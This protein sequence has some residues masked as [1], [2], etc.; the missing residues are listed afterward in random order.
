MTVL[1][2]KYGGLSAAAKECGVSRQALKTIKKLSSTKGGE[3]ARKA[4]GADAEFTSEEKRFLREAVEEIIVR[5]AQ[6]AAAS[7]QR[8]PQITM[9]DLPEL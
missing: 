6:V 1:E 4:A 7:C 9:A 2:E 8:H 3:D 5:A